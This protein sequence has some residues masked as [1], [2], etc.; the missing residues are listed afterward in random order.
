MLFV[1]SQ[2]LSHEVSRANRSQFLDELQKKNLTPLIRSARLNCFGN[3]LLTPESISEL[4]N[5]IAASI[6]A[7]DQKAY[8]RGDVFCLVDHVFFLLFDDENKAGPL[9][10]AGIVYSA[11]TTEPFRKLHSFCQELEKLLFPA[12]EAEGEIPRATEVKHWAHGKPSMPEGF[13]RFVAR[14]DTDS[15]FTS[16]RKETMT[17]R[18][19]ATSILEDPSARIFLR[20]AKDAH[21]EGYASKLLTGDTTGSNDSSIGRLEDA[22]LV[23][24][25]VQV[26]CR[27][28]GHALFRLPTPNA[29][30]VVTVSDA[31]CSECGAPVADEKV[32][33][34][35][36]P[37]RLA[38]SLLED[39]TWLISRLHYILREL[40]ISESEIAIGPSEG[41]GYGQMMANICGESFLIVA[42][43]GELT[44]AFA[45][46]A[47]DLEVETEASHL[48]VVATG[49]IHNQAAVLLHNHARHRVRAGQNFELILADEAAVAG[50][51]LRHAFERVSQRVVAE[52]LCELDSAL[53][54]SISQLI[55]T[56]FKLLPQAEEPLQDDSNMSAAE[57]HLYKRP[58]SLAAH[59]TASTVEVIDLEEFITP[60]PNESL[61]ADSEGTI[62][63]TV[64]SGSQATETTV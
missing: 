33:E 20:R 14:Q 17:K 61:G 57:T 4:E 43:D 37:T 48:V 10:R 58:L 38:A 34:V 53:G 60:E 24:R 27:K 59:A 5:A 46:W 47:I 51:E 52:Q 45:R 42:R 8:V 26:S 40:G 50:N 2:T 16:S 21:V 41:E 56:K 29:L 12:N 1:E 28:T 39:G 25:E 3:A 64:N 49:R 44:P 7:E 11:R 62:G 32:E 22:G 36:S 31:T 30:A 63:S 23:E 18:I 13:K 54:L 35:I 9:L 55:V 19:R 6:E 15:L